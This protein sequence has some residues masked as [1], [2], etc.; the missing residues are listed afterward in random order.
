MGDDLGFP[1][2]SLLFTVTLV[3][4]S[5]KVHPGQA[6]G[7]QLSAINPGDWWQPGNRNL[8][9]N[10]LLNVFITFLSY[11]FQSTL[12]FILQLLTCPTHKLQSIHHLSS[13]WPLIPLAEP[14]SR[15]WTWSSQ[16]FWASLDSSYKSHWPPAQEYTHQLTTVIHKKTNG[17][18][19]FRKS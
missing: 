2:C 19:C 15:C 14:P 9:N 18:Q 12:K 3:H 8:C 7:C 10:K 16:S 13:D 11:R 5:D 17:F 6:I 4:V 1:V